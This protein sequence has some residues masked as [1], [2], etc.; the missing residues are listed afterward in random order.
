MIQSSDHKRFL[1]EAE[2]T[3]ADRK[4][5][6]THLNF[7]VVTVSDATLFPTS[8]APVSILDQT[9]EKPA[10]I[11]QIYHIWNWFELNNPDTLF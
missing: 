10:M 8:F 11:K 7:T 3:E 9:V 6:W 1:K 2:S 5:G 4:D